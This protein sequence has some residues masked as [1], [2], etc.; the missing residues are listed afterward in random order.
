MRILLAIYSFAFAVACSPSIGSSAPSPAPAKNEKTLPTAVGGT[1]RRLFEKAFELFQAN[2]SFGLSVL[3]HKKYFPES[4]LPSLHSYFKI[5]YSMDRKKLGDHQALVL[6]KIPKETI[7]QL[8]Q[9]AFDDVHPTGFALL[10]A[11]FWKQ[12]GELQD[13]GF[14]IGI[15][16][17]AT[18]FLVN[19]VYFGNSRSIWIDVT[20]NQGVLLH[21][22]R[23]HVQRLR[24]Q[25]NS[26][27]FQ[28]AK[29]VLPDSCIRSA[30]QFFG[31]VDST[32]LEIPTW[33]GVLQMFEVR[34]RDQY[35]DYNKKIPDNNWFTQA[36]AIATN[37]IYPANA[38]KWLDGQQ[39]PVELLA[40]ADLIKEISLSE[41]S[42]VNYKY[43]EPLM[44]LRVSHIA[45]LRFLG[46]NCE[47]P[48]D[49]NSDCEKHR[50]KLI[51]IPQTAQNLKDQFDQ[52]VDQESVERPRMI[53][54]ILDSLPLEQHVDLCRFAS[55][56][57]FLSDCKGV[58]R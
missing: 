26:R 16:E 20:G 22:Y 39:C 11:S 19:G 53:R 2:L 21:E 10:Q 8:R 15:I 4:I 49:K 43:K 3:P 24:I 13:E 23:H 12:V 48:A 27:R 37:L 17:P 9:A 45:S 58:L 31:E 34:A 36:T 57:E 29:R 56:F 44:M 47:K 51:E 46:D 30:S 1:D 40:A 14:E 35:D 52:Y 55:G 18:D 54:E 33:K 25:V 41:E 32:N 42:T 38:R 28:N 7:S 5:G 6:R 50:K